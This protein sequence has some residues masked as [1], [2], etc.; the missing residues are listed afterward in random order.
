MTR[1]KTI[2]DGLYEILIAIADGP[3]TAGEIK[4]QTGREAH[5]RVTRDMGPRGWAV[6]TEEKAFRIT[7]V[8]RAALTLAIL[9]RS[10]EK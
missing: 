3:R 9:E 5:P 1:R 7:P 6:K 10:Q 4:Q 2:A 8:G